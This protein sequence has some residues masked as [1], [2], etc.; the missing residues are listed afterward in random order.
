MEHPVYYSPCQGRALFGPCA[1]LVRLVLGCG[2]LSHDVAL[3][4]RR[5]R[6]PPGHLRELSVVEVLQSRRVNGQT[7]VGRHAHVIHPQARWV[8]GVDLGEGWLLRRPMREN[9][10]GLISGF[11]DIKLKIAF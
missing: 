3:L 1:Q 2:D 10:T 5:P 6:P 8:Q 11:V 4:H 9:N 7:R